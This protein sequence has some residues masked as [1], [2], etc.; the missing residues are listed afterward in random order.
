MMTTG[1][2]FFRAA[3]L[4][5]NTV[6]YRATPT[7]MQYLFTPMKDFL[8]FFLLNKM[9]CGKIFCPTTNRVHDNIS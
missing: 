6:E 1:A 2:G 8:V 9:I 5:D 4:T 3:T 7:K